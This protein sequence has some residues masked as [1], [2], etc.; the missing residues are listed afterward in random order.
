MHDT[1]ELCEK[2][3]T[4]YPEIGECGGDVEVEYNPDKEAYTVDLKRGEKSLRTYL[5]PEDAN[6][7][8]EG[9]RCV[10][11]GVQVSQLV[12]RIDEI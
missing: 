10:S 9:E 3:K 1:N 8:M 12:N 2:I 5:E 11:L 6:T 7:C 4:I